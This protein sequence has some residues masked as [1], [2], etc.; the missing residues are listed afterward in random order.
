MTLE[1]HLEKFGTDFVTVPVRNV[2]LWEDYGIYVGEVVMSCDMHPTGSTI[3]FEFYDE[4]SLDVYVAY[5]TIDAYFGN[6][7]CGK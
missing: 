4:L 1:R 7:E 6:K 5:K 2:R 3:G